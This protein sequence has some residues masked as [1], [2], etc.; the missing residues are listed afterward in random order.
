MKWFNDDN[1]WGVNPLIIVGFEPNC[2]RDKLL[3]ALMFWRWC[4]KNHVGLEPGS[5]FGSVAAF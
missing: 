2:L 1:Y 5:I 3:S 4:T